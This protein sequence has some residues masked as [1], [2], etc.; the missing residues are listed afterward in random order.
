MGWLDRA[1]R[2][3]VSLFIRFYQV[4]LSPLK[5][6]L[7]GPWAGCRFHPTCSSYALECF[8]RFSFFRAFFLTTR[9]I[10]KCHPWHPGG[11]DPVP[12]RAVDKDRP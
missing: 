9:R 7:F 3:M 4:C 1:L 11:E 5:G 6:A 10:F 12:T 2:W 8:R